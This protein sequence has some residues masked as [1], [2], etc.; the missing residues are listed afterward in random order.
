MP[1]D[2]DNSEEVTEEAAEVDETPLQALRRAQANRTLPPGVGES[3]GRGGRGRGTN[4]GMP[5]RYNRGK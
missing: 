5:R 3:N 4:P 1:A 2:Q